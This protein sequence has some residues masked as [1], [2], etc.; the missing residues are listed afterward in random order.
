MQ[1]YR[2]QQT[3]F[4]VFNL[5]LM[6][7]SIKTVR[8]IFYQKTLSLKCEKKKNFAKCFVDR[9]LFLFCTKQLFESKFFGKS[10]YKQC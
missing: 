2:K 6:P 7:R 1:Y 3:Q 8:V 9:S 5:L 10:A 4:T